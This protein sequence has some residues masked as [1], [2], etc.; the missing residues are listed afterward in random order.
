[1]ILGNGGNQNVIR[2]TKIFTSLFGDASNS[3]LNVCPASVILLGDHTH[4]NDGILISACI[5]RYWTFLIKKRKD[6]GINLASTESMIVTRLRLDKLE[7]YND[8]SF[9]LLKGLIKMLKEEDLLRSGFDCVVSST[10]PEC[11]GL[12][13]S[14]AHQVGFINCI[15]KVFSLE[16]DDEKLLSIVRKNELNIIGKISNIAHHYTVQFGKEKKLFFIDLRT[17]EYKT[18]P[19]DSG[20]HLLVICDSGEKI[21]NPQNTCNERIE[22]CEVGVKGLRLYLWGI[23]NLRDIELDFLHKHYHMLPKR[24]FGRVLYN[25]KERMRAQEAIK[26]LRKKSIEEFGNTIN[27]SHKNLAEDYELSNEHCDYI[28]A[29]SLKLEGV[30]CSKLISC[31]PNRSTFHLVDDDKLDQ[32]SD[33]LKKSFQEKFQKNLK[34]YIVKLAGGVKKISLKKIEFSNQ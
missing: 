6:M 3:I 29:K 20:D 4:Y 7:N 28:V 22:E 17:K 8:D 19:L 18:I 34:I 10:V 32:F 27:E 14:A 21:I 5:D 24:I 9:R 12:G 2:T 25:V 26:H 23:K 1:M 31:S 30:H 16:I 11:V 15:R 33:I 13:S